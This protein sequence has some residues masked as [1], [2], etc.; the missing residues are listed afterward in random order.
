MT[1]SSFSFMGSGSDSGSSSGIQSIGN[2]GS[3]GSFSKG[4][5]KFWLL[6]TVA[7]AA[8]PSVAVALH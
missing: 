3:I 5:M 7:T 8:S 1:K 2:I 6:S 4:E